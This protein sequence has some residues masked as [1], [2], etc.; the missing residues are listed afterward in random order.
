MTRADIVG[1]L[2][3]RL[4]SLVAEAGMAA[5]DTTGNLKEPLDDALRGMGYAEAD[6]TTVVP[7][8]TR[9][10]LI[11][12]R[13]QTL[14]RIQEA[15]AD[16]FDVSVGGD[17]FKLQQVIDNVEKL[18]AKARAEMFTTSGFQSGTIS[19]GFLGSE[20]DVVEAW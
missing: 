6:L 4:G 13:Y 18:L 15:I 5:S 7:T 2:A 8:D 9:S 16:R 12:A 19:L 3:A 1:Y 10:V 17:S 20:A 11:S 14:L